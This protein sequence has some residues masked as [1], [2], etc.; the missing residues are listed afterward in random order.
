MIGLG[1]E[2]K[3]VRRNV[4]DGLHGAMRGPAHGVFGMGMGS[5]YIA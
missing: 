5:R 2:K 3:S 4:P 1:L